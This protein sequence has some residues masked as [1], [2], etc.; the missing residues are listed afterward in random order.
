MERIEEDQLLKR[1][2]GSDVRD[3][4]L[5]WMDRVKRALNEIGMPVEQRRMIVR[6]RS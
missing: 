5:R 1:T 2:V 3:V 6:D 4:R